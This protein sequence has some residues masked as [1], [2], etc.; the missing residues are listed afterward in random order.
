MFTGIVEQVGRVKKI[1]HRGNFSSVEIEIL[2]KDKNEKDNFLKVGD[3]IAVNGVCL[4][5]TSYNNYIFTADI[6]VETLKSTTLKTLKVSDIVNLERALTLQT[7]LGGHIVTGHVDGVGTVSNILNV[8]NA[9]IVTFKCENNICK[10]IVKKGSVAID[11]I[12]L[13]V[14]ESDNIRNTFKVG[15]IPHTQNNTTLKD[16][17]VG[18]KVNIEVDI[19]IR[20]LEQLNRNNN[21]D[22]KN[23]IYEQI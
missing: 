22:K 8:E 18:S 4:T 13:T 11:G 14:V 1:Q 20:Y 12:S 9:K 5:A 19:L 10:Y 3:S 15:L 16:I 17:Y 6:M 2:S 23:N 21:V 7:R